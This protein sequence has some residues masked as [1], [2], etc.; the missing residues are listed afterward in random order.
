[1]VGK[2]KGQSVE[3]SIPDDIVRRAEINATDIRIAL[4][5]Q[6]YVDN[7]IDHTD[8]YNSKHNSSS[9]YSINAIYRKQRCY[10][11]CLDVSKRHVGRYDN[12]Q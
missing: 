2:A 12:I 9:L 7:R 10:C 6:L 3:L 1:M 11:W 4:A 8:A 5:L